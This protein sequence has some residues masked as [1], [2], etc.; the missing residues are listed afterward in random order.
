MRTVWADVAEMLRPFALERETIVARLAT[1]MSPFAA[2]D[3]VLT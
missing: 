3:M 2:I 1:M